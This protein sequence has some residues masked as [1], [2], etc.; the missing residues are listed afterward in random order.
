MPSQ[1]HNPE[2]VGLLYL[3][4]VGKDPRQYAVCLGMLPMLMSYNMQSWT[5]INTS[6]GAFFLHLAHALMLSPAPLPQPLLIH[7][8]HCLVTA[9]AKVAD[10]KPQLASDKLQRCYESPQLGLPA[11]Q[12]PCYA[13]AEL[14]IQIAQGFGLQKHRSQSQSAYC[15]AHQEEASQCASSWCA[16]DAVHGKELSPLHS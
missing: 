16:T 11:T 3:I 4:S 5:A 10:N 12:F 9:A 1:Q 13:A 6:S 15:M 2:C 8:V 7:C 14:K